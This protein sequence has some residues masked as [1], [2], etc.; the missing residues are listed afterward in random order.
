ML[1]WSHAHQT[2]DVYTTWHPTRREQVE[3]LIVD[4][5]ELTVN[6]IIDEL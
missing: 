5:V 1:K 6:Y 2:V 4:R 3:W